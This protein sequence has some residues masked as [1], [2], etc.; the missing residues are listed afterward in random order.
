MAMH[1]APDSPIG[2][3]SFELSED[4]LATVVDLL[5]VGTA[6]ARKSVTPGMLEVP[7]V[8]ARQC[9]EPRRHWV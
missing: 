3:P 6:E 7:I 4:Q 1:L 2:R 9:F 5:C 8:F